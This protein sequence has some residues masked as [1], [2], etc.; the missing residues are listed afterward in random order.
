MLFFA[1]LLVVATRFKGDSVNA[2]MIVAGT[3]I[4][5]YIY[6]IFLHLKCYSLLRFIAPFAYSANVM[7]MP[8]L[9]LLVFMNFTPFARQT[10]FIRYRLLHFLPSLICFIFAAIMYIG[11]PSTESDVW[12]IHK[13]CGEVNFVVLL[14]QTIVYFYVIYSYMHKMKKFVR[15]HLSDLFWLQK[16]WIPR[17]VTIFL[18]INST[19]MEC[20][21]IWPNVD[22]WL[23]QI[24]NIIPMSYLVYEE[25]KTTRRRMEYSNNMYKSMLD[26]I[27]YVKQEQKIHAEIEKKEIN[28]SVEEHRFFQ[29]NAQKVVEYLESSEAYI[30]PSLSL[31]DVAIA[32]GI[33]INNLS[34]SI[35]GELG[36]SF[37]D[38]INGYRI[39]KSK[40]LLLE[41]KERGLTLDVIAEQCGFA[42][43]VVFSSAFKRSTGLT[44]TQWIRSQKAVSD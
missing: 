21:A 1:A 39:E 25:I 44:T 17:L 26:N 32:T 37:F 43:R 3:T 28:T 18:L 31:R 14:L 4:P 23:I 24:L 34:K 20:Y 30:N 38:L 29:L 15:E 41:K 27:I 35:N 40:T 2:A 12:A 16:L 33:S 10:L 9:W 11:V 22:S 6:N 8:L 19:M 36:K 5:V 7:L 13:K 42:S